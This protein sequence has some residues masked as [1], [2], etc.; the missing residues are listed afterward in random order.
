MQNDHK[1]KKMNHEKRQNYLKGT[2]NDHKDTQN[3]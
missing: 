1:H 3:D 2:Q